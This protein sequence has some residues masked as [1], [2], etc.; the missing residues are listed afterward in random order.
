MNINAKKLTQTGILTA[1][2][3]FTCLV[4]PHIANAS[5]NNQSALEEK[6]MEQ[7]LMVTKQDT[8][9][10]EENIR[11]MKEEIISL[12]KKDRR[13]KIDVTHLVKRYISPGDKKEDVLEAL[14][15]S[16]FEIYHVEKQY[17]TSKDQEVDEEYSCSYSFFDGFLNTILRFPTKIRVYLNVSNDQ[18]FEPLGFV[19]YNAI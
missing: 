17:R 13:T 12:A 15:N 3:V 18:I 14:R 4:I 1:V 7:S 9:N 2:L 19:F 16:G 10:M 8:A 11:L 5:P 6:A